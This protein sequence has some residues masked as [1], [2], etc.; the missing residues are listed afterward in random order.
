MRI[1]T[2]N[3]YGLQGYPSE[4]ALKDLG[5][6]GSEAHLDH[7]VKV[8]FLKDFGYFVEAK[9]IRKFGILINQRFGSDKSH[10]KYSS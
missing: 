3:A 6:I 2:Y 1:V 4:E 9:V 7:F 5:S 10:K 8:R